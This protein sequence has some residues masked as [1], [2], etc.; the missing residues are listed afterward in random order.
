MFTR[1]DEKDE[2]PEEEKREGLV[3]ECKSVNGVARES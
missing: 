2:D 1:N 3:E